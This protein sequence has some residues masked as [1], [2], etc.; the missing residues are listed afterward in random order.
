[1]SVSAFD[2][3]PEKLLRP[4]WKENQPDTKAARLP[5]VQD[6]LQRTELA[7]KAPEILRHYPEEALLPLPVPEEPKEIA[8]VAPVDPVAVGTVTIVPAEP[9]DPVP[10]EPQVPVVEDHRVTVEPTIPGP[11]KKKRWP[12]ILAAVAALILVGSLG[13]WYHFKT[14]EHAVGL[15]TS[16][17]GLKAADDTIFLPFLTNLHD[18]EFL[19]YL[20]GHVALGNGEYV[21]CRE[22][23]EPLAD[24]GYRDADE[25]LRL[26]SYREACDA[27]DNGDYARAVELL[28]PLAKQRYADSW[29]RYCQV[30]VSYGLQQVRRTANIDA[31]TSGMQLLKEAAADGDSAGRNALEDASSIVYRHAVS[32]YNQEESSD[33]LAYFELVKD[34]EDADKYIILCNAYWGTATLQQLWEIRDFANAGDLLLCQPYI[35]E[36]LLGNWKNGNG[37]YYFKMEANSHNYAYY[38]SYNIPWQYNGDFE[39]RDGIYYVYHNGGKVMYEEFRF[40]IVSWDKITVY[41]YKNGTTY[42]LYRQ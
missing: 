30:R 28:K 27:Q 31:V 33:A 20:D 6:G 1:M 5:V 42:T 11:K 36:F 7:A 10:A 21:R 4:E 18:P 14:Y 41:A 35:C 34:Y 12:G 22:L 3:N 25:V 16:G 23:L 9:T 24:A 19:P 26:A 29:Q 17:L 40:T 37:Y 39:I 8:P 38:S 2:V 15:A 32:L 13:I